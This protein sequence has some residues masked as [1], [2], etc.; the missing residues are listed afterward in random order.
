MRLVLGPRVARYFL[1]SALS[2][3]LLVGS[4]MRPWPGLCEGFHLNDKLV[5]VIQNEARLE[6]LR[7]E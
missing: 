7:A 5:D 1:G 2:S 4:G 6:A 3:A